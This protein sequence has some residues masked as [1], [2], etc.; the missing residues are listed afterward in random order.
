MNGFK[1]AGVGI[2]SIV[3]L[4]GIS[5][6]AEGNEFF[7]YKFFAPKNEQVRR[8]TFEQTKS[9]NQGMIQEIQNMQFQYYQAKPEQQA[10]LADIILHRVAD[11]D[12]NLLPLNT[13]SFVISLR[14]QKKGF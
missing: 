1:I 11:Y 6:V 4:L 8:E 14:N 13:R 5:W 3:G 10:M 2:L 12:I 7:L 9:Y